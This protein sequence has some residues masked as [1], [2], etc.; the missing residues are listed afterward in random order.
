LSFVLWIVKAHHGRIEV[1]SAPGKGSRFT[2]TLPALG[3]AP[4]AMEL[5]GQP[6]GLG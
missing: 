6:A 3:V 2:I 4:D 5:E 1:D